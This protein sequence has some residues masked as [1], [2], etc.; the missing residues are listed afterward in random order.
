MSNGNQLVIDYDKFCRKCK[1]YSSSLQNGVL[2]GID[3]QKPN[4]IEKCKNFILDPEREKKVDYQ[5]KK[6]ENSKI[7]ENSGFFAP[8]KKGIKSGALGGII[9]IAIAVL[10]FGLGYMAGYIFYYP[11]I[12]FLI[13]VYALIKGIITGNLKGE[14]H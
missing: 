5:I 14:N 12:L 9:M 13:G 1:F 4:F 8:E 7:N 6:Q 3:H 2:C 10:W 11:P